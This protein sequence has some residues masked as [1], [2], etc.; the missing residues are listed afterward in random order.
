MEHV[1]EFAVAD[2]NQATSAHAP[3]DPLREAQL[4]VQVTT[5]ALVFCADR[6][7]IVPYVSCYSQHWTFL[8]GSAV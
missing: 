4:A 3:I 8:S 7:H 6:P 2:S 5:G 1:A